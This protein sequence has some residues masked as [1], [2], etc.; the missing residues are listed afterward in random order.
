MYNL[1]LCLDKATIGFDVLLDEFINIASVSGFTSIEPSIIEIEN[2]INKKSEI[3]LKSTLKRHRIDIKQF[4]CAFGIPG[5]IAIREKDFNEKLTKWEKYCRLGNDLGFKKASLIVSQYMDSG[6]I[7]MPID[8]IVQRLRRISFIAKK[9]N[10]YV[11]LEI[12][13]PDLFL[14]IP[15]LIN[16]C[17]LNNIGVLIDTYIYS[18]FGSV[19]TL[20]EL[21]PNNKISWIHLSDSKYSKT[22]YLNGERLIPGRGSLAL[23]E[24]MESCIKKGYNDSV[25]I[26]VYGDMEWNNL[27]PYIR[28]RQAYE[29]YSKVISK[30]NKAKKGLTYEY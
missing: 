6:S 30:I 2:Y 15:E 16:S 26:E 4:S 21:I 22:N 14:L 11:S 20:N 3:E 10:I 18:C 28:A 29:G 8:E 13:D 25:S 19:H 7:K 12:I 5:N 24:I 23:R 27:N 1:N 9:Y 17:P